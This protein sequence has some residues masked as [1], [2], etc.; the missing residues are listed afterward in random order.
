MMKY[1]GIPKSAGFRWDRQWLVVNSKGKA[2]TQRVEPK[3]ALVEIEMPN[4][5]FDEGWEPTV[6]FRQ[7]MVWQD[8]LLRTMNGKLVKVGDPVYVA[9]EYASCDDVPA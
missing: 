5:A 2:Y 4:G 8:S 7:N 6:Y 1:V 3:L 9:R